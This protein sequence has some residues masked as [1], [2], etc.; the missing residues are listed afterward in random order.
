MRALVHA[1]IAALLSLAA[2]Q[3]AAD[4]VT[5]VFGGHINSVSSSTA[6]SALG[7]AWQMSVP[8]DSSAPAQPAGP[9]SATFHSLL[10]GSSLVLGTTFFEAAGFG[11]SADASVTPVVDLAFDNTG[12]PDL[13]GIGRDLNVFAISI[14]LGRGFTDL[15]SMSAV[16][17][18]LLAG[19][20]DANL[21][22]FDMRM[23]GTSGYVDL[24]GTLEGI[25]LQAADQT[26]PEPNA[27]GLLAAAAMAAISATQTRRRRARHSS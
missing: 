27:L 15:F 26:L 3:A 2:G 12:G 16:L 1:L 18:D 14:G 21:S 6:N 10:R 5:L 25:E 19:P 13:F 4:P 7:W 17:G 24:Q 11:L 23:V 8:F 9:D 20:F 22:H